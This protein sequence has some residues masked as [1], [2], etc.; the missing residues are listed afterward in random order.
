MDSL[1]TAV[2]NGYKLRLTDHLFPEA[3]ECLT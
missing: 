1:Q 3:N 2:E